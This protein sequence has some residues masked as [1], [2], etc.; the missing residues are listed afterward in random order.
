MKYVL[1]SL[2]L[3]LFYSCSDTI[4]TVTI[5]SEELSSRRNHVAM[6]LDY[7]GESNT[8]FAGVSYTDSLQIYK[9]KSLRIDEYENFVIGVSAQKYT[10]LIDSS[11]DGGRH[12][13]TIPNPIELQFNNNTVYA[14]RVIGFFVS[15]G[16]LHKYIV[17]TECLYFS[18]DNGPFERFKIDNKGKS[19]F[20]DKNND[21]ILLLG[22]RLPHKF[23]AIFAPA[24]EANTNM[25]MPISFYQ[26]SSRSISY[27][28]FSNH[29][30]MPDTSFAGPIFRMLQSREIE[31]YPTFKVFNEE[32][33]YPKYQMTLRLSE[34][35]KSDTIPKGVNYSTNDGEH[36]F[37]SDTCF[38]LQKGYR[39][40]YSNTS[41]DMIFICTD[42]NL[43]ND[44]SFAYHATPVLTSA[45]STLYQYTIQEQPQ[46]INVTIGIK[47]GN[48]SATRM[49]LKLY[50]AS[51]H[52]DTNFHKLIPLD[53]AFTPNIDSTVWKGSFDP[54][55]LKL[56]PGDRYKMMIY[57][58][59]HT[60]EER[61]VLEREF[62][63]E[64]FYTRYR[65]WITSTC[66]MTGYLLIIICI[67]Y[68]F[69]LQLLF[70][71]QKLKAEEW[72]KLAG[73]PLNTVL[74]AIRILFPLSLFVNTRYVYNAW[75]RKHSGV[76]NEHFNRLYVVRERS[77]YIQI[78]LSYQLSGDTTP[79]SVN[80][81]ATIPPALINHKRLLI[82]IIGEG[83]I[84]KT[85]LGIQLCKWLVNFESHLKSSQ[86]IFMVDTNT[87]DILKTIE[88]KFRL[89]MPNEL[90]PP[91]FIQGLLKNKNLVILID[92]LSES[93]EPMQ[94]YINNIHSRL[95]INAMIITSRIPYSFQ[96]LP[97]S[98]FYPQSLDTQSLLFFVSNYIEN[99]RNSATDKFIGNILT[100]EQQKLNFTAKVITIIQDNIEHRISPAQVKIIIDYFFGSFN[101][102]N[103]FETMLANMPENIL[104][105]YLSLI[106]I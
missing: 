90:L 88:E 61:F 37:F 82:Q 45:L 89:W 99:A 49:N 20:Y 8:K 19:C 26:D 62:V 78:P 46:Q 44:I 68:F 80:H 38:N 41:A 92:A 33:Y 7:L 22:Q 81:L 2:L 57:F 100:T 56:E 3:L 47:K 23:P 4:T 75:M 86:G 24:G 106:H 6:K 32:K 64:S 12:W 69:P 52:N 83:G 60:K 36:G 21:I 76:I 79:V 43:E 103:S 65:Q 5:N 15:R 31:K 74:S 102:A 17:S 11:S 34:T 25:S 94:E 73:A 13:T 96:Q 101:S 105:I 58:A 39:L 9:L 85:T 63:P 66:F 51:I 87:T 55:K 42:S 93:G 71:N 104:D 70:L 77:S 1:A 72:S 53:I 18:I 30:I 14:E 67:W 50:A 40:F 97:C 98:F 28:Q 35:E 59:D 95:P 84:G 54:S 48:M 27:F 10:Y 29:P 91:L 16:G